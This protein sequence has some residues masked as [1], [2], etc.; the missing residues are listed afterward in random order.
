MNRLLK[1]TYLLWWS[2]DM[3]R[4]HLKHN[5]IQELSKGKGILT[6]FKGP[7]FLRI[8]LCTK[9]PFSVPII[10]FST[11]SWSTKR[12]ASPESRLRQT[13]EGPMLSDER[14]VTWKC[15]QGLKKCPHKNVIGSAIKHTVNEFLETLSVLLGNI[16][17]HLSLA[18]V[19]NYTSKLID[20]IYVAC[21][22]AENEAWPWNKYCLALLRIYLVN[23]WRYIFFA[24][25]K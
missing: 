23:L 10:Q 24:I 14:M 5:W 3:C 15:Y 8:F 12:G 22:C 13:S 9:K 16:F 7:R 1:I 2:F 6:I 25:V 18:Y 11:N 4:S 17:L 19:W 21:R 20:T